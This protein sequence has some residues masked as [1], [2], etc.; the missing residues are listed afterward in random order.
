MSRA[1]TQR[2]SPLQVWR[3]SA[4]RAARAWDAWLASGGDERSVRYDAY[5]AALAEEEEAAEEMQRALGRE[6]AGQAL[7]QPSNR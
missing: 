4:Q 5:V 1:A 7:G 3:S 6:A 2:Q